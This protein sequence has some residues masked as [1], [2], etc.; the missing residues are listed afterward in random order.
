MG[1]RHRVAERAP[2]SAMPRRRSSREGPCGGR[3][4]ACLPAG[5]ASL[6]AA[7]TV[8]WHRGA[9]TGGLS[10]LALGAGQVCSMV[11][12]LLQDPEKAFKMQ[13]N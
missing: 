11:F 5:C 9:L 12:G 6:H 7:D 8:Q 4:G 13:M 10:E 1:A 2:A 3:G